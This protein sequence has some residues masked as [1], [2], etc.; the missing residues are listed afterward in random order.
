MPTPS[1]RMAAA[2]KRLLVAREEVRKEP[3]VMSLAENAPVLR[4]EAV[5]EAR[6]KSPVPGATMAPERVIVE[7]TILEVRTRGVDS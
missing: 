6:S 3:A 4:V 1:A 7:A 5:M 2:T